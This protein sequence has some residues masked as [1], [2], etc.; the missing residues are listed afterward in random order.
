LISATF[1][2]H[3]LTLIAV[4][5]VPGLWRGR[6]CVVLNHRVASHCS[7]SCAQQLAGTDWTRLPAAAT[8]RNEIALTIR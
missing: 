3:A 2:L 8:A 4:I 7:D 6:W 5:A 1:A